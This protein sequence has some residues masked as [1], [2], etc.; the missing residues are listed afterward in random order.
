MVALLA[1]VDPLDQQARR[2]QPQNL[3]GLID[4]GEA[5]ALVDLLLDQNNAVLEVLLP[6]EQHERIVA[7]LEVGRTLHI[8][9]VGDQAAFCSLALELGPSFHEDDLWAVWKPDLRSGRMTFSE[10]VERV[11]G[12]AKV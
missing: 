1:A 2:L 5:D 10:V 8:D 7:A 4:A 3:A 11:I 12:S 6:P 9:Q